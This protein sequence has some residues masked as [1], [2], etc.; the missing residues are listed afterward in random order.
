MEILCYR[1]DNPAVGNYDTELLCSDC[2][3]AEMNRD[4]MAFTPIAAARIGF[5][6]HAA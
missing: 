6:G 5:T 1:C 3:A 2:V 4:G